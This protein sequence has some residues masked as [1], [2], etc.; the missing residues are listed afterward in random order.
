MAHEQQIRD[1]LLHAVYD[2]VV[3]SFH[4]NVVQKYA[5]GD[6]V[7]VARI[8]DDDRV[9]LILPEQIEAF[10]GQHTD[11]KKGEV[12]DADGLADWIF[13]G[14]QLVG[15]GFADHGGL[16]EAAHILVGKHRAAGDIPVADLRVIGRFPHHLRVPV[17][18][19]GEH[20]SAVTHFRTDAHDVFQPGNRQCVGHR[21]RWRAAPAAAH[22]A[23]GEIAGK[24]RDHA[25]TQAADLVLDLFGGAGSQAHRADDGTDA[26]DDAE[27]RQQRTHLVPAQCPPGDF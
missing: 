26:D 18:A 4:Q 16:R 19:V 9:V 3:G 13:V 1:V 21:Q 25:F 2:L 10:G 24:N 7:H 22:R 20:L 15:H 14:K 27:H 8:R 6:A 12:P 23:A 17:Q 11:N 5:G